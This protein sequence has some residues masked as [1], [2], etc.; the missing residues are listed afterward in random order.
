[1]N[2]DSIGYFHVV[3][4]SAHRW[5]FNLGVAA[6]V[7]NFGIGNST[8]I[9][10]K[11][12]QPSRGDIT[13]FVDRRRQDRAAMFAIPHWIVG[14]A[15]EKRYAKWGARNDHGVSRNVRRTDINSPGVRSRP[16]LSS[17][18]AIRKVAIFKAKQGLIPG[19]H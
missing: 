6:N 9:L 5:M 19:P 2:F 3:Q 10:K 11:G 4:A 8:V 13:G 15:T 14:A 7:L 12:R 18:E 1:M 16:Q 17:S